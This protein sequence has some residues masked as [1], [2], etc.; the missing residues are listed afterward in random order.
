M[1]KKYLLLFINS[2]SSLV[3]AQRTNLAPS[4]PVTDDYHGIK[5][6]DEYRSLENLK[7]PTTINWMKSQT[8]YA[9]SIVG[10]LPYKEYF[11]NERLKFDKRSGYW[12]SD[13]K[14]TRND[15]YFYLKKS[16][17]EKVQKLYYRKGLK[18]KEQLLY[19][20]ETF[21]STLNTTPREK[22]NFNINFISPSWDGKKI[23]ISM[24]ENG[25][26]A[27]EVIIMD[28]EKKYIYPQVITNLE[29]TSV[30]QIKWLEDNKSF[31]YT[32]FP[33]ID[34]NSTEYTKNT[35]V[36]FYK[37]GEDPKKRIN[38]FS[39]VNNPE[40]GIDESR[41]PGIVPFNQNDPYFI[42]NLGD[43]DDYTDTFIINRK[44]FEKGTKSWK[45]LYYKEDKVYEKKPVGKDIYFMSGYHA[46]NFKLCKTNLENPNFKN[47]EVLVPEKKEEVIQSFEITKDGMYYTTTKNGIEAKLYLY[48]KGKD[49]P[50]K[51]PFIAGNVTI[52]AK[53]KD[54][55][56]IWIYCSGWANE[57][58]RYRYNLKKNIFI[59]ENLVPLTDYHEF[60]G[61]VVKEISIKARDGEDVPLT[62]IY[63]KN[64]KRDGNN[65]VLIDAYGAYGISNKPS[66]VRSY[67]M[68]AKKGGV[69]AIAHVRGG[70]E[71]G[72]RWHK[73]GY[74]ETKPNSWRDLID[75]TE[76]LIK[77]K[78]TSKEKAGL[79]GASAGGITMGRAITERP[80]LFKAAVIDVGSTNTIRSEITPNGPGNIP[81]FGTV[82]KL[83][84][85][86]ALL[87]MDA[88]H[89]IKKGEKYPATLVTAGINDGRVIAWMP[90]KFAAKLIANNT[91]D[92]PI[93]LK[94]D[95]QGGHGRGTDLMH[96]YGIVGEVFGFL[97]WQLGLP[98]Y[99]TEN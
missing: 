59:E 76:Y 13:L 32:Y 85:F 51:L 47:P 56:D 73:A 14:I 75:C 12:I 11:I 83:N 27:S 99:K 25:K 29:P 60:D 4:V 31:F 63:D 5:V 70:G 62:L 95:Y 49:I 19:D 69:V 16:S 37:L 81:E 21:V 39:R 89:H 94:V 33:V 98:G 87:E 72:D 71:K 55:S 43:V 78:Y 3:I 40:L 42:G 45:P 90:A 1:K 67:L 68:W 64:L 17:D 57:K 53:G 50:I 88:F 97:A 18:G 44:D 24:S 20:P 26:E 7:D 58:T 66:F 80:D 28:V 48:Q 34:P 46:S 77:E 79:W 52:E 61:V 65:V 2:V 9:N 6:V 93:L 35:E 82:T 8:D 91:S 86:K 36:T 92:N 74:K 23:A 30:G 84:E 22:N 41:F 10:K 96:A 38:V 54:Y 15:L